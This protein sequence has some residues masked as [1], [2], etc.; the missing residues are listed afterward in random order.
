MCDFNLAIAAMPYE[1][2]TVTIRH[3]FGKILHGVDISV[4]RYLTGMAICVA[5]LI[6]SVMKMRKYL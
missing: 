6:F 3:I 4:S 2:A 1:Y 5:I